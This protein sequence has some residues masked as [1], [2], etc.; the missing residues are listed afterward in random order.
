MPN[1]LSVSVLG[2][3]VP[4]AGRTAPP[5]IPARPNPT[6][7]RVLPNPTLRL[8]AALGLVVIEFRNDRGAI[9]NSYPSERQLAVYRANE[10]A[11]IGKSGQPATLRPIAPARADSGSAFSPAVTVIP[12]PPAAPQRTG[13][14]LTV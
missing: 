1:D 4:M 13:E 5:P 10:L 9:E 3:A 12:P 2:P 7:E 11:G 6:A 8:E 14:T